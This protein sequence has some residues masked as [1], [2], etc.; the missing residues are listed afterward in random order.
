MPSFVTSPTPVLFFTGKGG[1]GKT[2]LACATAIALADAGHH[3]LLVSTDP[4]SNLADVLESEVGTQP[5]PVNGVPHLKVLN[6]DPSAAAEA[7]RERVVGPMRGVLPD[8]AVSRIEEGLSGACT[9]EI[10]AFDRF[11]SLLAGQPDSAHADVIIFDTAP[12]GHTLRLLELPAAW[13]GFIDENPEGASCLGPS[14]ALSSQ[15]ERFAAAA[16]AL[17]DPQKT[18]IVLVTRPETSALAEADRAAGELAELG[19][20]NQR[21]VVNGLFHASDPADELARSLQE[22]GER[23]IR[24]MPARLAGLP[25]DS[26]TLKPWNLL[27]IRTLRALLSGT[28]PDLL[29]ESSSSS[30]PDTAPMSALVDRI[31]APGRGLIMVMGK[32]GVGKTTV[33]SAL[34][35]ELAERGHDVHLTTTDPAAHLDLTVGEGA[36][37]TLRVSRIDPREETRKYVERVLRTKGA[38]LDEEARNLLEEDLKSPCTEEVAV[39]HAFSRLVGE[40]R[41]GFVVLD[42]APTGHTLLLLDAAGSYHREVLRTSALPEERITTPLMR[43]QD[44][45]WSKVLLVTLPETTP[46]REASDLQDDLRRASVEP[47]AWIVNRSLAASQT[48]DPLLVARAAAEA[49]PITEVHDTLAPRTGEGVSMCLLPVQFPPPIGKEALLDLIRQTSLVKE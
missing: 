2:S 36:S 5:T 3:T 28:S 45:A 47:F 26:I 11:A 29:P 16:A 46:I 15:Q 30:L 39:F 43:L 4:A 41:K 12:T 33:A 27:G 42:T 22:Y 24:N 38:S 37:A 8:E 17:R 34:A 31:E 35:M 23:A 19:V 6:V 21:L 14:S 40:A 20:H 49:R 10:A 9:T 7:Y 13:S 1:V 25:A 18:T 44:P 32:G 48:T